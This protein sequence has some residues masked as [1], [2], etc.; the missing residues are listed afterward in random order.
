MSRVACL[1]A[2]AGLALTAAGGAA[3]AQEQVDLAFQF[4]P[5]EVMDYDLTMS[6]SG[7]LR[8]PDG[9]LA[10]MGLQGSLRLKVT[11][12]EVLPD[13]NA[14]LQVL[15][16]NADLRLTIGSQSARLVYANGRVRWY[17]DGREQAPPE[18]DI[19]QVPLLG[20]PLELV[21]SPRGQMLDVVLPDIA[22]L[23]GME[24][25]APGLGAPQLKDL[26]DP[27]FPDHPVAVG[28]T[29]RRSIQVTP[30]GPTMPLT[31]TSSRTLDS[32]TEQGGI[33]L[34]R[35]SGYTD[36]R[37]RASAMPVGPADSGM[38]LSV[39]EMRERITS[40]EFFNP[41]AG[42]L[43]RAHYALSFV[44]NM[45]FSG[46]NEGQQEVGVEARLNATIQAR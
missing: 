31:V 6:G 18:A 11:V 23:A 1:V 4:T 43:V 15:V 44:T 5:G 14:R 22:D 36:A 32:Y 17:A 46:G 7:E 9:E 3:S 29:W 33:G 24:K 37:L 2:L 25:M 42:R 16:P 12:A 39:P 21:V 8:A 38:A 40:T 26:G 20:V 19:N 27:L 35:I 10:A 28:E 41:T 13:G 34:A 45:S 30:F